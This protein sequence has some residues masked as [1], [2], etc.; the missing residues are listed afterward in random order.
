MKALLYTKGDK[1]PIELEENEA[2]GAEKLIADASKLPNTAFSIPGVWTGTKADMKFVKWPKKELSSVPNILSP[3]S[4]TEVIEFT[5]KLDAAKQQAVMVF[6]QGKEH[7]WRDFYFEHVGAW[8]LELHKVVTIIPFVKDSELAQKADE[9]IKRF[10]LYRM[11]NSGKEEVEKAVVAV[12]LP[13]AKK[14]DSKKEE[15]SW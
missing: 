11:K 7:R 8:R 2:K 3:M 9:D 6:G 1:E 10:D 12:A 13:D 5:K 14:A 15:E 4:D